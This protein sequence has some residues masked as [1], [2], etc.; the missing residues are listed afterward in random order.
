MDKSNFADGKLHLSI[1]PDGRVSLWDN[2]RSMMDGKEDGE[3]SFHL[4]LTTSQII[5]LKD[6][7][8]RSRYPRKVQA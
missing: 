3:I 6:R 2:E 8:A 1:N 5:Q 7:Q 4:E